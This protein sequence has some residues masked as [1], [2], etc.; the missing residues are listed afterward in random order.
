MSICDYTHGGLELARDR[1]PGFVPLEK[2][3]VGRA[4]ED[5]HAAR[6]D[7]WRQETYHILRV[8]YDPAKASEILGTMRPSDEFMACYGGSRR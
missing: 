2:G 4:Y 3:P 5:A 1:T 8:F 7:Q 6:L